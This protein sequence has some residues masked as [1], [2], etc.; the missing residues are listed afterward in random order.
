MAPKI[1]FKLSFL[2]KNGLRSKPF[3]SFITT[4]YIISFSRY[5]MAETLD[6]QLKQ[7]SEDLREVI[8]NINETSRTQDSS[9][10]VSSYLRVL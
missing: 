4:V 3:F 2:F 10:P 1:L 6:T 8:E 7:M 9:D 5:H